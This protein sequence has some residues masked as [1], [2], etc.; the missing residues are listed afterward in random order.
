VLGGLAIVLFGLIAAT[1]GRIWVENRV[2]F[3]KSRNLITVAVA[4]TIGAG[5]LAI[6]IGNFTLSGIG[7]ATFGSII[8][9]QILRERYPQPE[10]AVT[11]DSAV[12]T[13]ETIR[14]EQELEPGTGAG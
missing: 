12:G 13:G 4:L 5:N 3:S 9:Y 14:R 6:N 10:E 7:L 8:L 2:D 11:A 1:G